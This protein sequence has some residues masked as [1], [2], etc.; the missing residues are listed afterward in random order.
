MNNNKKEIE[1]PVWYKKGNMLFRRSCLNPNDPEHTY[2]YIKR[3][4]N[5]NPENYGV[6]KLEG[7]EC[8]NCG[9]VNI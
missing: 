7:Y 4:Y 8:F 3:A 2:N 6:K 5:I 9:Y 1:V